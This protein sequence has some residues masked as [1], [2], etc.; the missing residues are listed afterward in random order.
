VYIRLLLEGADPAAIDKVAAPKD[1]FTACYHTLLCCLTDDAAGLSGTAGGSVKQQQTEAAVQAKQLLCVQAMA[2]AYSAHAG[3]IG[4]FE[5]MEHLLRLMD[6][7][8]LRSLRHA[9]LLLLQALIM[10]RAAG[11]PAAAAALAAAFATAVTGRGGNITTLPKLAAAGAPAVNGGQQGA[12]GQALTGQQAAALRAAKANGYALLDAGG[13]E[14][15]VAV[16]A[17]AHECSERRAAAVAAGGVATVGAGHLLTSISHEQVR[18]GCGG[19]CQRERDTRDTFP[20]HVWQH[21]SA[22]RV[23]SPF[24]VAISW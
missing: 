21:A 11:P 6:R 16:V 10:P 23:K 9:L 15:L 4:P 1:L 7:T 17:G 5:G 20:Q 18:G 22:D 2:A 14:L 19:R 8:P 24:C 3:V 12:P 13:L